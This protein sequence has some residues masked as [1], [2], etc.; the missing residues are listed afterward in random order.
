MATGTEDRYTCLY[1][2]LLRY[3]LGI[4]ILKVPF[5]L[6]ETAAKRAAAAT[7]VPP[8]TDFIV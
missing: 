1:F 5:L 7:T 8:L 4:L 3:R 2:T 6:G